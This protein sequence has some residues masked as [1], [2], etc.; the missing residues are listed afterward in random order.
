MTLR[1]AWIRFVLRNKIL[2]SQNSLGTTGRVKLATLTFGPSGSERVKQIAENFSAHVQRACTLFAKR[3]NVIAGQRIWRA[4]QIASLYR[5]LYGEKL[6]MQTLRANLL[7][8]CRSNKIY[9][10]LSAVGIFHWEL[11]GVSDEEMKRALT[12][13]EAME[14]LVDH[15]KQTSACKTS[16]PEGWEIVIDRAHLKV[17]RRHMGVHN[18]YEYRV[19]GTFNDISATAFYNTQMDLEFWSD[20]DKQTIQISVVDHDRESSSEVIHWVYK[21]PYPMYPR[22]YCYVRRYM[23]NEDS[24]RMV[25]RGRAV[26]HPRC[27]MLNKVVRVTDYHSQ[28]VIEPHTD[29]DEDGFDYFMTYFDDPQTQLPSICYNWLASTGVPEF[30]ERLHTA[31]RLMQDRMQ[32]G[33][34]PNLHTY[35]SEQQQQQ[36]QQPQP[37]PQKGPSSVLPNIHNY[38]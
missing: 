16:A 5:H 15:A 23:I 28:M 6:L 17:W 36:Q 24:R 38:C 26:E 27:P 14:R 10:L 22:D 18:L 37:P 1:L 13:M 3:C 8:H 32:Q 11:D 29:F 2:S 19:Y 31:S 20:W 35:S 7:R 33:Y 25:I 12:E 34:Q 4:W 21:F 9:M 30:V